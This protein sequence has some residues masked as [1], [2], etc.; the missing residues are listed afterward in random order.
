MD[1]KKSNSKLFKKLDNDNQVLLDKL[2][3]LKILLDYYKTQHFA[4]C[5]VVRELRT[6]LDKIKGEKNNE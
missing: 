5:N 1:N 3:E 6:E 4:V 2:T